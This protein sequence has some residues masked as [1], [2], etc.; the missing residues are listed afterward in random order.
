MAQKVYNRVKAILAE[1]GMSSKKLADLLNV[2]EQTVSR[3]CTNTRQPSIEM[4][5]E[6]A[7]VLKRNVKDFLVSNK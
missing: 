2:S 1:E 4:L 6:I 7:T 5:Y 3:W